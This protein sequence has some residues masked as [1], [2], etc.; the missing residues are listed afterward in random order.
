MRGCF[1]TAR[2]CGRS[3]VPAALRVSE[4]DRD[5]VTAGRC[6]SAVDELARALL[7]DMAGERLR[8]P[9]RRRDRPNFR[10]LGAGVS[11]LA[12]LR[13][14]VRFV[15]ETLA[16]NLARTTDETRN[17]LTALEGNYVP[18]GPAGSPSRGMAHVLPTGR[19]FYTVDPRG[20]PTPAAWTIGAALAEQPLSRHRAEAALPRKYCAEHLG[21]ADHAHRWRRLRAGSRVAGRAAALGGRQSAYQWR[22]GDPP[23]RTRTAADR[24]HAA[25]ERL[26]P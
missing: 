24:C 14:I 5:R 7:Q 9:H 15:C 6:E 20:L 4:A 23:G 25:G 1:G 16:P 3:P 12:D 2:A 10:R 26:L 22:R 18:A 19:N 21:H 11:A 17:L 13:S 8:P